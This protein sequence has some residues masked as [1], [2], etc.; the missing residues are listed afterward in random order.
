MSSE[1]FSTHSKNADRGKGDVGQGSGGQD[2]SVAMVGAPR[3][4]VVISWRY[5]A[6]TMGENSCTI[7]ACS[8]TVNAVHFFEMEND[9]AP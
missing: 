1:I 9:Q 3:R 5:G 2:S 8:P 4:Q 7:S 6:N